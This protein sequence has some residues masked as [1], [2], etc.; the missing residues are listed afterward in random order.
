MELLV[1]TVQNTCA[2]QLLAILDGGIAQVGGNAAGRGRVLLGQARMPEHPQ[3]LGAHGVAVLDVLRRDAQALVGPAGHNAT[4]GGEIRVQHPGEQLLLAAIAPQGVENQ[5][6]ILG[7]EG[8]LA[9]KLADDHLRRGVLDG[10]A[11]EVAHV[12][13]V[14]VGTRLAQGRRVVYQAE[15]AA[16]AAKAN[17]VPQK[18][19]RDRKVAAGHRLRQRVACELDVSHR[20][21]ELLHGAGVTLLT[22]L[23]QVF[24]KQRLPGGIH[25]KLPGKRTK[26]R[27][28]AALLGLKQKLRA[29]VGG[30]HERGVIARHAEGGEVHHRGRAGMHTRLVHVVAVAVGPAVQ[31]HVRLKAVRAARGAQPPAR[32]VALS[33]A[34]VVA[35]KKLANL[36]DAQAENLVGRRG[37]AP[38][39][40]L[41]VAGGLNFL[42][43]NGRAV[44][45]GESILDKLA[46]HPGT[47][48]ARLPLCR[49]RGIMVGHGIENARRGD[50]GMRPLQAKHAPLE[51]P[52]PP[53]PQHE[54]VGNNN[55]PLLLNALDT[56]AH[57]PPIS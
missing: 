57:S 45:I 46:V 18:Q 27:I 53:R 25:A 12:P 52:A 30:T 16:L 29:E 39:L 14:L 11:S 21:E 19:T 36:L 9:H 47:D 37:A 49:L 38:G 6:I 10:D 3:R 20:V 35:G 55:A 51:R 34:G 41:V 54:L 33:V 42:R 56:H 50:E 4:H 40:V 23:A 24:D 28:V 15:L 32:V 13:T 1:P 22:K 2:E 31:V 26:L 44:L 5:A 43:H 8:I 7:S 17:A 48:V